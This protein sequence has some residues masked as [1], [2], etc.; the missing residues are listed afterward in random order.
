MRRSFETFGQRQRH[1]PA[2]TLSGVFGAS[3]R[4]RGRSRALVCEAP[5]AE[6]A[7][8]VGGTSAEHERKVAA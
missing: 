7:G 1:F 6:H 5:V 2:T 3:N 4:V 8:M